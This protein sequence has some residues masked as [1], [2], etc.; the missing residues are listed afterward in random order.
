MN[1]LNNKS[2][3]LSKNKIDRSI[4][5]FVESNNKTIEYEGHCFKMLSNVELI[6]EF[7]IDIDLFSNKNIH[8]S[9]EYSSLLY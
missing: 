8:L 6:N 4:D 9:E 5:F 2:K 1:K 3:L 7:D